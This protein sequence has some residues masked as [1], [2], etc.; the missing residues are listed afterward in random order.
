MVNRIFKKDIILNFCDN[1][2]QKYS[3]KYINEII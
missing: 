3:L 2:S 1:V